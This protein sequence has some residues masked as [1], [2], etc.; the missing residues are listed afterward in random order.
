MC[1]SV[2]PSW[3][4]KGGGGGLPI[5]IY[6]CMYTMHVSIASGDRKWARNPL[7]VGLEWLWAATWF[8][9]LNLGPL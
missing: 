1:V 7:E 2:L 5:C 3:E 4:K 6:V 8:W 9:E